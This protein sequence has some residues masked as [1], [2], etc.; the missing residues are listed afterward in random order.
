MTAPSNGPT[1]AARPATTLIIDPESLLI[2]NMDGIEYAL[3]AAMQDLQ[4]PM[5]SRSLKHCALSKMPLIDMFASLVGSHDRALLQ[6]FCT[7]FMEHFHASGRYRGRLRSGSYRLLVNLAADP[8][9][10]IHYL[11]HIGLQSAS[12]VLD[13]YGIDPFVRSVISGDQPACPGVRLALLKHVVERS[14]RPRAAWC[15]ITD[16]PWELMAAREF[17]IRA[18]ALGYG[19]SPLQVL[20]TYPA[21][22]FATCV[23]DVEA[24][25]LDEKPEA[26]ISQP[27]S[28]TVH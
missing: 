16:H 26:A 20:G 15:L 12:R 8:R 27:C 23:A 25:L 14:A 4:L 11:T 19:R 10:E 1:A 22:A 18:I 24:H 28:E 7:A 13:N 5:P 21:E 9:F 17:G 2:D 6:Q 3:K